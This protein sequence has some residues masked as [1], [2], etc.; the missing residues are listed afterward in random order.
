MRVVVVGTGAMGLAA[1]RVLAERGHDVVAVDQFGVGNRLA[2]S[3]GATRVWRLADPDRSI[4]RLSQRGVGLWRDL[5]RRSGRTV[6]LEPGLLWRGG[7]AP[8][9]H[10]ALT[11]EGEPA[12]VVG[13][14]EQQRL[15]PE[16]RPDADHP[17]TWTPR[18]GVLLAAESL[19]MQAELLVRAGGMLVA[20]ERIQS[21]RPLPG[22]GVQVVGG[23]ATYAADVAVVAAGP[24]A[25]D[26]MGPLGVDLALEPVLEQVGYVHGPEGPPHR[27][28]VVQDAASPSAHPLYAMPSPGSGYK[29][30]LDRPLRDWSAADLERAPVAERERAIEELVRTVFP[31]LEPRLTRSEVCSWTGSPDDRFVLDRVGDVVIGAGDAGVAFKHSPLIG[32]ILADLVTGVRLDAD[33]QQF[34]LARFG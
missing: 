34:T 14:A 23:R 19:A 2:S 3:S 17:V 29:V 18:A 26:F 15:F 27:P 21:V 25:S 33:A 4:V 9:V 31:G 22:G 12:E 30:G 24:W 8:E 6:L 7:H 10:T 13:L 32:E 11:A 20:G 5:E 1:A 28:C 16:L